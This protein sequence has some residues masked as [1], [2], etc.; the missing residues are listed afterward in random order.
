MG[1]CQN[2]G[3]FLGYPKYSVPYYNKDPKR[4]PNFDNHPYSEPPES[5]N[6][7]LGRLVLGSPIL[8][9]TGMR[10]MMFQLSGFYCSRSPKK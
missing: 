3:P 5:W 2:Y 8:Y 10:I 9:L 4:D 6:M 7:D 1:S